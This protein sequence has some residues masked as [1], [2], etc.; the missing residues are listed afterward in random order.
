[1]LLSSLRLVC[2]CTLLPVLVT[3]SLDSYGRVLGF[4]HRLLSSSFWGLPYRILNMN[5]KKELLRSLWVGLQFTW[6]DS[7]FCSFE[8]QGFV[9]KSRR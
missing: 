1:M 6:Q 5:H 8:A 2:W 9:A 7:G 3:S 4:T